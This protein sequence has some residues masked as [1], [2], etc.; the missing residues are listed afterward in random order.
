MMRLSANVVFLAG[1][2]AG[3]GNVQGVGG[4]VPPLVTFQIE[5]T[6]DLTGLL[7]AGLTGDTSLQVALVWGAQWWTEPFCVEQ[8]ESG[9]V[10]AVIAAGC[11]DPFGFVPAQVGGSV[12][13]TLNQ[14]T[15]LS[16]YS[17]PTAS[18]LVG[19][20]TSRVGYASFVLYDD[21]DRTGTLDLSTPHTAPSGGR[22]G[23]PDGEVSDS[24]DIVYG[25]SFITM[26]APDVRASFLEGTYTPSAFYPRK[27]CP[28]P[29]SAF[30]VLGAGGFSRADALAASAI[31]GIPSEDPNSCFGTSPD[32][33]LVSIPAQDP[34]NVAEVDCVE[35][36]NDGSVRYR[37]P[38]SNAPDLNNR[39]WACAHLP[40][41]G[42]TMGQ[43]DVIQ[44]VVSGDAGARCKGLTHYTLR[45]CREDVACAIPDWDF[46]ATPP[47]WWPCP[48]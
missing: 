37:Q 36:T 35:P 25:A 2:L 28:D 3:C 43:S 24:S 18:L 10:A 13:V 47:T 38:P 46:T 23:P 5:P 48:N 30:Q 45:G 22:D 16:L 15:S 1:A 41:S 42:T 12:P 11:R 29:G 7:P 39:V 26:T 44:L 33:T 32:M 34:A 40:A 31:G 4:A 19:G 20:I 6:G 14:A 17:L 9:A 27:G 21:R 8:P